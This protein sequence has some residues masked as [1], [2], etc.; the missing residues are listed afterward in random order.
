MGSGRSGSNRILDI[1]DCSQQTICRNEVNG[2]IKGHFGNLPGARFSD[3]MTSELVQ[4]IKIATARAATRRSKRDRFDRPKK[5]FFNPS[6]R[7]WIKI[8]SSTKLRNFGAEL[9][10]VENPEEFNVPNFCLRQADLDDAILVFKLHG[11][12]AWLEAFGSDGMQMKIV[13]NIRNPIDFLNSWYNRW[14]L[15]TNKVSFEKNFYH[16]P[17]ILSYFGK[18]HATR[19]ADLSKE[20]L[21]EIELWRWRYLN[22]RLFNT[23]SQSPEYKLISYNDV[24]EDIITSAQSLFNFANIKITPGLL[25]TVGSLENTLF[26]RK[27]TEKLDPQLC[28]KLVDR[29]LDGSSLLEIP[30]VRFRT[31]VAGPSLSMAI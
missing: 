25:E 29:V 17:K 18:N 16:V 21:L 12:Q 19:L 1:F 31:S 4:K 26:T 24:D 14:A 6:A 9:N 3:E 23:Y 30:E 11:C 27:H 10:I 22:E 2:D 20:S 5:I 15:N 7:I 13:H 28:E 8:A